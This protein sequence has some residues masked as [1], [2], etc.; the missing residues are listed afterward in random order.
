MPI[1]QEYPDHEGMMKFIISALFAAAYFALDKLG[2]STYS[3]QA[4]SDPNTWINSFVTTAMLYCTFDAFTE[5]F[6]KRHKDAKPFLAILSFA[7]STIF[8]SART[9]SLNSEITPIKEG[10]ICLLFF[11]D[12]LSVIV[13]ELLGFNYGYLKHENEIVQTGKTIS[14]Y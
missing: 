8:S 4:V 3:W 5:V 2:T 7:I 6:L 12:F 13:L 9:F 10:V 14:G 11:F 1:F